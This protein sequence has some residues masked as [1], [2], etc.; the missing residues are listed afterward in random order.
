[1]TAVVDGGV[2]LGLENG[3]LRDNTS[4]TAP[5]RRTL[6]GR[7]IVFVQPGASTTLTLSS[8]GLPDVR[9]EWSS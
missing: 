6:D 4:Y 5:R 2:L 8:L 9:L 1:M 3:D 7:L